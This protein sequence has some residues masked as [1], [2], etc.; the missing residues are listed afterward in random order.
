MEEIQYD[1][2]LKIIEMTYRANEG[3]L[4]SSLSIVD[5][6]EAI[7]QIKKEIEHFILS[8]G[9]A[10]PAL[11]AVLANHGLL[12][13]PDLKVLGNHP[14]R[15]PQNRIDVSTGSLGQGLPIAVGMA[16]AD[17]SKRIFCCSSDGEF[18]EGSNYESLRII[19][20]NNLTNLVLAVNAN[21]YGAYGKI[22][23]EKLSKII[24]G[25]GLAVISVD[26]HNLSLLKKVLDTPY[27][28]PTII[29][30]KTKVDQL[31]FL[32]GLNA[33]YYKM[34]E[35]DYQLAIKKWSRN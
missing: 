27:K 13:D 21:G 20:D 11:Y 29:L 30:A 5:I 3:H 12:K 33:H 18:A 10:V 25:F 6:I 8:A 35:A 28:T 19:S 1:N 31:P 17:R 16:L 22:N 9:Q 24:G 4:S 26:G 7:Y 2:R 34:S 14:E 23:I 32:R 15:N